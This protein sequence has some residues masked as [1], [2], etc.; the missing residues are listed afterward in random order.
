MR[1][2]KKKFASELPKY[3]VIGVLGLGVVVAIAKAF[4]PDENA[5]PI[6]VKTADLSEVATTGKQLFD[7]NCAACHGTNAAG[8][9]N[10]PPLI[11]DIYNPG[12][13]PDESFQMAVAQGVRQHH[14]PFGNMPR[15]PQVTKD[16]V[17]IIIEYV[18]ELQVANGIVYRQHNM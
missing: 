11:H 3:A 14:W 6:Q 7:E 4:G 18:R 16:Q 2:P 10:G 17:A 12:H 1:T 5:R 15:Q 9:Q 8:S 13:H